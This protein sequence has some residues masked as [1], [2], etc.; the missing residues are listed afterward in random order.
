MHQLNLLQLNCPCSGSKV[1]M[2]IPCM[3]TLMQAPNF[4]QWSSAGSGFQVSG[5]FQEKCTEWQ[6]NDIDMFEAKST[7]MHY[8]YHP[9]PHPYSPRPKCSSV[10]FAMGKSSYRFTNLNDPK[11]IMR[12]L[13][14]KVPICISHSLLI[15]GV[16]EFL[17]HL[18]SSYMCDVILQ[19][20]NGI[21]LSLAFTTCITPPSRIRS[22][23]QMWPAWL[24]KVGWG[25]RS[26][27]DDTHV[28]PK[29]KICIFWFSK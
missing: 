21:L 16:N 25:I 1:P 18:G 13:R 5:Q 24:A 10:F 14:S 28:I 27:P 9:H 7:K 8:T 23:P 12:C 17:W 15:L 19:P 6:Q 29:H 22:R 11:M 3:H 2:G 20:I 4:H 26:N